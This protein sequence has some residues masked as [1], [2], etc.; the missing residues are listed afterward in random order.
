MLTK[1]D[2]ANQF[3]NLDYNADYGY[4][5]KMAYENNV[6]IIIGYSDDVTS[7]FGNVYDEVDNGKFHL[8]PDVVISDD[9]DDFIGDSMEAFKKVSMEC[10]SEYT[11]MFT[12]KIPSDH[13]TFTVMDGETEYGTGYVIELNDLQ[14]YIDNK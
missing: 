6:L 9:D 3:R 11:D 1:K 8:K 12:C 7:I 13:A 14:E 10:E 5:Q 2:I 4:I